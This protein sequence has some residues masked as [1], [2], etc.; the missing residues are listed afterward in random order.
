MNTKQI[1]KWGAEAILTGMVLPL[2]VGFL[3]WFISFVITSYQTMAEVSN[4]KSDIV[5]IKENVKDTNTDVKEI[6]KTI[7]SR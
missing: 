3:F 4:L 1:R 6:L 2:I 7:G 5:E